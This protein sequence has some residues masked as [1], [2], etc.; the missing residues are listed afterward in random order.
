MLKLEI[1]QIEVWILSSANT[2]KPDP[3]GQAFN[4][5]ASDSESL[6]GL[7]YFG[8]LLVARATRL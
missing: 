1:A 7:I 5:S 3:D 8:L 2:T 6:S 4:G